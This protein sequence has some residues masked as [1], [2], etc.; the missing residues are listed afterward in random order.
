MP[1]PTGNENLTGALTTGQGFCWDE[2]IGYNRFETRYFNP[3]ADCSSFVSNCLYQ[4]GFNVIQYGNTMD[5]INQLSNYPGFTRYDWS[6]SFQM[7][8][9][10]I[11]VYDNGQAGAEAHT[12][13]YVENVYGYLDSNWR[14]ASAARKGTLAHA[15]MEA[16]GTHGHDEN[17]DQDNGHGAHTEVWIH[18]YWFVPSQQY[19]YGP[20]VF[21]WQA[22][23]GPI[24]PP[25]PPGPTPPPT[26]RRKGFPIWLL[27]KKFIKGLPIG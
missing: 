15:R 23:P 17:G 9:G 19:T 14:N 21:R 3:N 2:S 1:T 8:H 22:A 7:Q 24:P 11:V 5:L 6:T 10:D 16:S 4:N 27:N 26:H 25:T 12:F 13:F 18:D 20:Y